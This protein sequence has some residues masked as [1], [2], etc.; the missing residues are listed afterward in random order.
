M[1]HIVNNSSQKNREELFIIGF[2]FASRHLDQSIECLNHICCM[3]RIVVWIFSIIVLHQAQVEA[4]LVHGNL[5]IGFDKVVSLHKLQVIGIVQEITGLGH[6]SLRVRSPKNCPTHHYQWVTIGCFVE[7]K[8][9][10]IPLLQIFPPEHFIDFAPVL[11]LQV[12]VLGW[13]RV[14]PLLFDTQGSCCRASNTILSEQTWPWLSLCD[15]TIFFQDVRLGGKREPLR[16]II[17]FEQIDGDVVSLLHLVLHPTKKEVLDIPQSILLLRIQT[18]SFVFQQL[19]N[20]FHCVIPFCKCILCL[21]T[22]QAFATLSLESKHPSDFSSSLTGR[23]EDHFTSL[24]S[25]I[26][27]IV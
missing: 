16:T 22:G 8:Y 17:I 5:H 13:N 12:D 1:V 25:N 2:D 15:T 10:K 14:I 7:R 20:D 6:G 26:Y 24:T 19:I 18:I 9:I 27:R 11:P 23:L 4:K 3:H 21:D